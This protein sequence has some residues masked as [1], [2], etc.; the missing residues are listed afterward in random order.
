[1]NVTKIWLGTSWQLIYGRNGD[2]LGI[3]VSLRDISK[4][5]QAEEKLRASNLKQSDQV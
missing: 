5:K 1:M 4:R 3:P 2:S